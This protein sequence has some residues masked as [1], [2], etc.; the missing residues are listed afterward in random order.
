MIH[1]KA[2]YKYEF[3]AQHKDTLLA[4]KYKDLL[5]HFTKFLKF[6]G[7]RKF[8]QDTKL[9]EVWEIY[10]TCKANY[11]SDNILHLYGHGCHLLH[12]QD[13]DKIYSRCILNYHRLAL[14]VPEI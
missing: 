8:R 11:C 3:D 1:S 4:C 14:E 5:K 13:I 9:P 2:I 10:G 12:S 6:L 7:Y